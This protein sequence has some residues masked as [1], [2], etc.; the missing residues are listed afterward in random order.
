MEG[1]IMSK[2]I[3]RRDYGELSL[4]EFQDKFSSEET[5]REHLN[6][7]RWPN[8]Y[9]CRKCESEKVHYK[10]SRREYQCQKCDTVQSLTAGTIFHRT[11]VPIRKWFWMIYLLSTSKKA[12]STLYLSQQLKVSYPTAWSM[13]RKIQK[14]MVHRDEQYALGGNVEI[15]E[16]W[17]GGKQTLEDRRD[18]GPNKTPFFIGVSE[19][20]IGAPQ[21]AKASELKTGYHCA[22][23]EEAAK[24]AIPNPATIKADA[25]GAHQNMTREGHVVE[26][27]NQSKNPLATAEHLHWLNIVTSNLKRY[28]LS[29]HHGTF[30]AYRKSYVSEFLYRFNRRFW[31]G[32]AFDRLLFA[33]IFMGATPVRGAQGAC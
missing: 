22:E 7:M 32:Q 8:G 13:R 4:L 9:V 1:K 30:P 17:V 31:P 28:L 16:I 25:H 18:F 15:D 12:A 23:I 14:A 3:E 10:P 27:S 21:F 26:L 33:N 24:K 6:K 11:K 5:C 20:K 29:T 2:R 19:D